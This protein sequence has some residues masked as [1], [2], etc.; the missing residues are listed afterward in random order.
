VQLNACDGVECDGKAEQPRE[1]V[2]S[3]SE[4]LRLLEVVPD[5]DRALW[6]TAFFAGLRRGEL[7]G[8]RW[9]D[10]DLAGRR[11]RIERS[12]DPAARKFVKPKTR[13]GTRKVII[14]DLLVPYLAGHSN[15][16]E[17]LVFAPEAGSGEVPVNDAKVRE[18]AYA[19]WGAAG[20]QRIGL[21][22]CRHTYA[23]LMIAAGVNIKTIS[24]SMG[25][26]SI[27]ITLDR[28]G[29]LLDG[30]LEQAATKLNA[31]LAGHAAA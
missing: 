22:E 26:A 29:H 2:A 25:H 13:R 7:L 30:E 17:G 8:L 27:V 9:E 31:Y 28:Y 21:H 18:R 1:R 4:A 24:E 19:A 23:S 20:L 16:T 12:Y 11:L 5:R 6:A 3:P 14:P 10:V 15:R